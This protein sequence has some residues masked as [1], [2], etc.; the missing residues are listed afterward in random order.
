M[1]IKIIQI[2]LPFLHSHKELIII[3]I[4]RKFDY[5]ARIQAWRHKKQRYYVYYI[6]VRGYDIYQNFYIFLILNDIYIFLI[7]ALSKAAD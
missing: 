1:L 3:E 2:N 5:R 7:Y 4:T 6:Y